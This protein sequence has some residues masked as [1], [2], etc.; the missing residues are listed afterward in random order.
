MGDDMTKQIVFT[1][2]EWAEFR[3]RMCDGLTKH[4]QDTFRIV[5]RAT[6][7]EVTERLND[8]CW[9]TMSQIIDAALIEE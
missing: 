8:Y 6:G 9:G 1:E 3:R 7:R 5:D 4:A 2:K